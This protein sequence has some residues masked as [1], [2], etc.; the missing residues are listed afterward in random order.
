M[1]LQQ[2]RCGYETTLFGQA[3]D[4]LSQIILGADRRSEVFEARR[5]HLL[6]DSVRIT[7]DVLPEVFDR[8]QQCLACIGEGYTGDLFVQRSAEYNASVLNEGRRFDV[9]VNS[10]LLN[11]FTLDELT[12]VLGHELGHVLFDHSGMRVHE[13]LNHND[14]ISADSAKILLKWSRAAE[15]SADRVGILCCGQL[16]PATNAL[17]KTASGLQSVSSLQVIKSLRQQYAELA[18]HI[19]EV[20]GGY[21]WLRTHPMIPIRFRAIEMASLDIVALRRSV[22][23]FSW[24]GFRKIDQQVARLLDSLEVE[25]GP[26]KGMNS[27]DGQTCVIVSLLYVALCEGKLGWRERAFIHD[28]HMTLRSSLPVGR[29]L[30]AAGESPTVAYE[31]ALPELRAKAGAVREREVERILTLA[32]V[33]ITQDGP[34]PSARLK[35]M[36]RVAEALGGRAEQVPEAIQAARGKKL[37]DV[38]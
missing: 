28:T 21:D 23:T 2:L 29:M 27:E 1:D 31:S 13:A 9:V 33:M 26:E 10:A 3:K 4:Q 32:A 38:L 18:D 37:R 12:F 15:I 5:R 25:G 22:A 34:A 14:G 8:Y 16:E 36:E 11:D 20:G 17:F 24:T 35:A 30:D 6:G 19:Q 7:R